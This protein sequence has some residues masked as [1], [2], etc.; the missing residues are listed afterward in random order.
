MFTPLVMSAALAL[1]T[2]APPVAGGPETLGPETLHRMGI[3]EEVGGS[4]RINYA[5][6]LRM[7][8]QRIPAAACNAAAGIAPEDSAAAFA[9]AVAEYDRILAALEHG[10]A[11]LGIVGPEQDRKVLA[12]IRALHEVWD[13]LHAT[14]D[15]MAAGGMDAARAA[16]VAETSH[17]LLDVAKHLVGLITSEYAN[18]AELMQ[19]DAIVIDIAG[20]QRMLAQRI[21]KN[22]CLIASGL[23]AE[24]A[25]T[26]MGAT[27]EMYGVSLGALRAGMPEAGIAPPP[28]AEIA[29]GL[30]EI[31]GIWEGLQPVLA[32]L[33]AGDGVTEAERAA[34]FAGGNALTAKM[35]V[36]VGKYSDASAQGL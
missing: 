26:E 21:S 4:E 25:A 32:K 12:D 24:R 30:A 18:P 11:D 19:A 27:I 33:R 28:T 36:L 17:D 20:R 1:A 3:V 29:D 14:L 22:A 6:K 9:A 31:A 16:M 23:D 7:L 10:D 8:S 13:P 15:E 2:T 5:G 35:N 34:I